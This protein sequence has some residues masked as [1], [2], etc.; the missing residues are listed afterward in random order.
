[1]TK[2]F[3][4]GDD[5]MHIFHI[6]NEYA[7]AHPEFKNT[8]LDSCDEFYLNHGYLTQNQINTLET[9]NKTLEMKI[10]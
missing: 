7:D 10:D 5:E 8:F 4:D 3:S 1:M 9:I 2:V 6:L